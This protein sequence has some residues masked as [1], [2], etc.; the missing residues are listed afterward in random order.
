METIAD[1][2]LTEMTPLGKVT[3]ANLLAT[4]VFL[5]AQPSLD[6]LL[7]RRIASRHVEVLALAIYAGVLHF[8]L[9]CDLLGVGLGVFG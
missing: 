3:L 8:V 1:A 2:R 9:C 7:V 6:G 4:I 5:L